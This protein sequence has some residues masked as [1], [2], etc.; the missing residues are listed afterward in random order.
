M[1]HNSR[2]FNKILAQVILVA[3]LLA[4]CAPR[5]A[6]T[7]E[8]TRAAAAASDSTL[9]VEVVGLLEALGD[10]SATVNGTR[11]R[12]NNTTQVAEGLATNQLVQAQTVLDENGLAAL[13]I[14]QAADGQ[15]IGQ[16][17]ELSG[18]VENIASST[19]TVGGHTVRVEADTTVSGS[20]AVGDLVTVQGSSAANGALV[21][22]SIAPGA[23]AAAPVGAEIEFFGVVTSIGAN[24]WVIGGQTV[25]VT[26]ATELKPGVALGANV[27]VHATPQT[28]GSL[29]AREIELALGAGDGTA[30]PPAGGEQEFTGVLSAIDGDLWTVG[31]R[32][33][34]ITSGTE[35]KGTLQIG[36]VLKVHASP[37]G[38]GVLVAREVELADADDVD[39]N[40]DD[41]GDN[42]DNSGPGNGADDG[43]NSGPGN[44][45][46]D[47]DDDDNSGSGGGGD[48]D[49][50][51]SGSGGD[52]DNS[53]SGGGGDDG[54]NDD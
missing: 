11:L 7:V 19:W 34:R 28:D 25:R 14:R 42:D 24:Q 4:A 54:D 41:D 30:T 9:Y 50:S 16:T 5:E 10:D 13:A 49:N 2:S 36:D 47:G 26:S 32:Q 8:E 45:D 3:L 18:P 51:G 29:L 38:D 1:S 39:D 12:V 44:G 37:G 20:P 27:K 6:G 31:G 33:V 21:A 52:D 46:D 23:L 35:V 43:D 48:D 17:F 22:R 40:D 53:G 15:P